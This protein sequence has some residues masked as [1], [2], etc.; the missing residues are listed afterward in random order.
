[1]VPLEAPV[2]IVAVVTVAVV[3][4]VDP[5][6]IPRFAAIKFVVVVESRLAM[7]WSC[8]LSLITVSL[9]TFIAILVSFHY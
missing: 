3:G 6:T 1:M 4:G 8:L 5:P 7:F 2:R 9:E